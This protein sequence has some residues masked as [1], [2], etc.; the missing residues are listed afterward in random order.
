MKK[1]TLLEK[2]I[3]E[4]RLNNVEKKFPLLALKHNGKSLIDRFSKEDPSG[5]NKYLAWMTD[6]FQEML[7]RYAGDLTNGKG[8]KEGGNIDEIIEKIYKENLPSLVGDESYP[9][10]FVKHA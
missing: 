2:M 4:G 5:N 1:L 10:G 8:F 6:A 7:I 3:I 9:T